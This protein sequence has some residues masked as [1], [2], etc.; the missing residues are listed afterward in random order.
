M[1]I[2]FI[3]GTAEGS[4]HL[5]SVHNVHSCAA[6]GTADGSVHLYSD[7]ISIMFMAGTAESSVH[8]YSDVMF[9]MFMAGTAEAVFTSTVA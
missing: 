7:A 2:M 8:L 3:A 6:R 4:V 9:I 1:L 5:Y